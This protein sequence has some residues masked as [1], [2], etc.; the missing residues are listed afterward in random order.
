MSRIIAFATDDGINLKEDHFGDAEMY[1]TY[2]IENAD[3]TFI[4][5]LTKEDF[6]DRDKVEHKKKAHIIISKLKSFGVDMIASK[7]FGPNIQY[8]IKNFVPIKSDVDNIYEN[9]EILKDFFSDNAI[10]HDEISIIKVKEG[11]CRVVQ[12]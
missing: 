11:S 1:L 12:V 3:F 4:K 5:K 2:S 10:S 7:K 9:I 8:V 6:E